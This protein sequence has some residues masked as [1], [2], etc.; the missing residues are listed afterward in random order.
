MQPLASKRWKRWSLYKQNRQWDIRIFPKALSIS[1]LSDANNWYWP[2]YSRCHS[3]AEQ[4][5]QDD[6]NCAYLIDKIAKWYDSDT[7]CEGIQRARALHW[8][9]KLLYCIWLVCMY[10]C[11][12]LMSVE[13]KEKQK[14]TFYSRK[15]KEEKVGWGEKKGLDITINPNKKLQKKKD[16][17]AS[18]KKI[19]DRQ[20]RGR[21]ACVV[22]RGDELVVNWNIQL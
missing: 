5:R 4:C 8:R 17:F 19:D 12:R 1:I 9:N 2:S 18:L 10:V 7:Q 3:P 21:G 14:N 20:C 16:T 15:E 11:T 6:R 13:E 22:G